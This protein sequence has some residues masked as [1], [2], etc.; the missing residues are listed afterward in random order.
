MWERDKLEHQ[1]PRFADPSVGPAD[2]RLVRFGHQ[3]KV[4]VPW[5]AALPEGDVFERLYFWCFVP[6]FLSV[7]FRPAAISQ[8]G[9]FD[10]R[11]SITADFDAWLRLA[12]SWKFAA[13]GRVVCRDCWHGDR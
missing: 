10:T 4:G 3:L 6:C 1:V 9:G 12:V 2:G 5:P 13:V 7:V 8:L 11:L